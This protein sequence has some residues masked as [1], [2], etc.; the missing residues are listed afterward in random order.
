MLFLAALLIKSIGFLVILC[1]REKNISDCENMSTFDLPF[2]VFFNS[3][4]ILKVRLG[5]LKS[6]QKTKYFMEL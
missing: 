3:L 4:F 5:I 6:V 1:R 2:D